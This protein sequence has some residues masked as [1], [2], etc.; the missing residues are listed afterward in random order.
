MLKASTVFIAG[1]QISRMGSSCSKD[2]NSPMAFRDEDFKGS[3]R[4]SVT[5][6]VVSLCAVLRLV[7]DDFTR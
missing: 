5:G 2:P 7:K 6:Y 1:H 4:E 3:V